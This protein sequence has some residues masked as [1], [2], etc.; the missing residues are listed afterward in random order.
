M[1][2]PQ[3]ESDSSKELSFSGASVINNEKTEAPKKPSSPASLPQDES[4][5]SKELSFSGASVINNDKCRIKI[6]GI[7][8]GNK[9][10]YT[11]K[12]KLKN[13][14]DETCVFS[15]KNASVN[16]VQT[17]VLFASEVE[18][19][20]KADEKISFRSPYLQKNDI[21]DYTDI[22]ITF[23]VYDDEEWPAVDIAEKTVHIYPYGKKNASKFIRKPQ[24]SDQVLVDNDALSVVLTGC[25]QDSFWG[26]SA[27]LFLT[28][29]S[30]KTLL[31][32]TDDCSI[33]DIPCDPCYVT[34]LL[35]GKCCF[36]SI[37][38]PNIALEENSIF[39]V[40]KIGF[41]L[42]AADEEDWYAD[43]YCREKITLNP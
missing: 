30:D 42:S 36:S 10:G 21:G 5:S 7:D 38:W 20:E 28:N 9:W 11:L 14:S 39:N 6:T 13:R 27:N 19:G 16:G 8:P 35:P 23:R 22:E 40:E 29:R 43:S 2:L 25:S 4:S 34:G 15:V 37:T 33:N 41:T 17:D 18:P 12:A 32:R 24:P 26:Y 1:S 3:D 31:I